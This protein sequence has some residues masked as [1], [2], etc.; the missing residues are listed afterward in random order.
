MTKNPARLWRESKKLESELGKVGKI[1]ASTTIYSAPNRYEHQV[2]YNVAIVQFEDGTR[3]PYEVVDAE[4]VKIGLR[5][6]AVIRR[7]GL[8]EP[9]ELIEYGIKVKPLN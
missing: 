7:I 2:P 9:E 5:V 6:K 8:S 1:I 4:A 3:Q